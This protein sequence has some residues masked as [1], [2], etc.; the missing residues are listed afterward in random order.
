MSEK[1]VEVFAPA[2]VANVACGFDVLGF[3]LEKPGDRVIARRCDRKGVYLKSIHI[4][5]GKLPLEVEKNS[6]GMAALSL[7]RAENPPFGIELELYKNLP[8]GSGLGSSA[9]SSA[10][11]VAAANFLLENPLPIKELIPFAMEGERVACG[12]AHADNV[13]PALIGGFTLIR[14]YDPL[15]VISLVTKL[16]LYCS[17]VIPDI[18]IKTQEARAILKPEIPMDQAIRQWGNLGALVA[19]LL[20]GDVGLVGRSLT[21]HVIEH[22]R[23]ILIP[24]FS[25]IKTAALESGALGCSI[26]GSGPAIFALSASESHADEIASAMARIFHQNHIPCRH[27]SSP[28]N[29]HGISII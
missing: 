2:T 6:A 13:A 17:I 19:G 21:D 23:A 22:Q 11:G 20:Q 18:E 15:E 27:W 5:N 29:Q 25:E 1:S 4:E 16:T 8:L 28:I 7:W 24:H 12:S 10:A 3:A 26:S 14:S 9:A